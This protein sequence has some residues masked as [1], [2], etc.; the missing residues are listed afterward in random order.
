MTRCSAESVSKTKRTEKFV[1]KNKK[2]KKK[3]K[4]MHIDFGQ[5]TRQRNGEK[6]KQI[7]L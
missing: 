5:H 3:K 6:K 1:K 4:C 2:K 7:L